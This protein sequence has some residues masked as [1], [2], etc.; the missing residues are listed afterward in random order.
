MCD[1]KF[2]ERQLPRVEDATEFWGSKG[3]G[4]MVSI[5]LML[6]TC[7]FLILASK[8]EIYL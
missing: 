5:D 7:L 1:Q 3:N 6:T 8:R 4:M 2:S